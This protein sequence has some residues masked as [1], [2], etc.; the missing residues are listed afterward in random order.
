MT[1]VFWDSNLFIYLLERNS[2]F[3]ERVIHIRRSMLLRGDF[4]F[5]SSLT[6]GEVMVKPT[7]D[8]HH[9]IASRYRNFFS[10]PTIQ[11]V[12][13]DLPAALIYA[14]IRK[15]RGISRSDAIQLACAGSVRADL[16]ITNDERLVGKLVPGVK[17]VTGL[18]KT[19]Y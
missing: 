6:V 12:P 3:S 13:F 17:F 18:G 1:R 9:E 8:G 15:D 11:V 10:H 4:L 16:F 7:R 19:P 5:T 2:V 14:S